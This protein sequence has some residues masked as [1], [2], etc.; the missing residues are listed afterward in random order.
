MHAHT[1]CTTKTELKEIKIGCG[2]IQNGDIRFIS[3]H[4]AMSF[5]L[6]PVCVCVCVFLFLLCFFHYAFE[7]VD[8]YLSIFLQYSGWPL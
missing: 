3:C 8:V 4:D 6:W 5:P 7:I 1:F 2:W